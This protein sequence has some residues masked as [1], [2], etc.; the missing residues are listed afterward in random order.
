[1][2]ARP[3]LGWLLG[4][5]LLVGCACNDARCDDDLRF[6]SDELADWAGMDGEYWLEVCIEGQCGDFYIEDPIP[7]VP[8]RAC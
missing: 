2:I 4:A 5:L 3:G 1:M 6:R 8:H 7:A